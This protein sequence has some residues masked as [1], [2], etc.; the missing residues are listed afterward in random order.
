MFTSLFRAEDRSPGDDFWYSPVAGGTGALKV[1]TEAA[2]RLTAVYACVRLASESMAILPF[3][4]YR[5]RADGRG[6]D[7]VTSH[8]LHRLF[9]RRPN[10]WQ[11]PFSWRE[12]LQA[13][14]EL[15]GNAFCRI[16]EGAR[17]EIAQLVPLHP[18]RVMI[19]LLGDNRWR[20]R[21]SRADGTHEWLR[22]DQ[23][24]HLRGLSDDG[25]KG[26][27]PIEH[28]R[29]TIASGI[30]ATRFGNRQFANDARPAS[31]WIKFPGQFKTPELKRKVRNDLQEQQSGANRGKLLLLD[32]DMEYHQVGVS[33]KDAQW[34]EARQASVTDVARMFRLPPHKIADLSRST[35]NNIEHQSLE[36]VTDS[37]LPRAGRWSS[38][39][40]FD[41]LGEQD[42]DLE[43]EFDFSILLKGDAKSRGEYLRAMV[44]GGI[45]S[46]NEARE[47]DGKNPVDGL[48]E[49]LVPANER[50]LS[51]SQGEPAPDDE[52][53]PARP[54]NPAKPPADPEDDTED[55]DAAAMAVQ[56]PAP[57]GRLQAMAAAAAERIARKECR[58]VCRVA[59]AYPPHSD[60]GRAA[61]VDLY[62]KHATF[63][64]QALS[65]S[66]EAAQAYCIAQADLAA[67][68]SLQAE[69]FES[70]AALRLT[71][72]AITGRHDETQE[73]T[74]P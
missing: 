53:D 47:A 66:A 20:Y 31:G 44:L 72:L 19:E 60:E 43:V 27:N 6:R 23:V 50:L 48:D 56:T 26:L 18:D 69:L 14:L 57:G 45:Y 59:R 36:F 38:S 62:A 74:A 37:M 12:M 54:S 68:P 67:T 39:I 71:R 17:G 24:W 51:E 29:E 7:L 52:T 61:M 35:N 58:D 65:V 40:E 46:R 63:V 5:R 21:Y 13:H 9:S 55:D 22:R 30:E 64:Q 1:T 32:Q 10:Q 8:W 42:E 73:D 49:F 33:A 28:N 16:I 70:L 25:V 3:R 11:N 41:L 15:R 34:L 4:L 2:M